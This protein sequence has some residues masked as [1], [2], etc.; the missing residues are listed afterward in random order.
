MLSDNF[1]SAS[2]SV[3]ANGITALYKILYY[4]YYYWSNTYC[5]GGGFQANSACH[6]SGVIK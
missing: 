6:P 3:A 5:S 2:A 1:C 4:Y